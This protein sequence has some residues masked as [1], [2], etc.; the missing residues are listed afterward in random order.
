MKKSCEVGSSWGHAGVLGTEVLTDSVENPHFV[1]IALGDVQ[2]HR[3][4]SEDGAGSLGPQQ[5][6]RHV[7]EV[8]GT[9]GTWREGMAAGKPPRS[10][11]GSQP[12][13]RGPYVRLAAV[14]APCARAVPVTVHQQHGPLAVRAPRPLG[15]EE[16]HQE[17]T[18]P[19]FPPSP[20]SEGNPTMPRGDT[21]AAP[22]HSI[23]NGPSKPPYTQ[24]QLQTTP[25]P[26]AAP[27][28]PIPNSS[29][30]QGLH[31]LF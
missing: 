31:R 22:N 13:C 24:Q 29:S 26:L 30:Q 15:L 7:L 19:G 14:R 16:K 21:S 18:G 8:C 11:S 3:V 12:T 10:P 23:P 27:N 9:Q 6:H 25:F 1:R 5:H 17:G 28:H 2:H 20:C 4:L